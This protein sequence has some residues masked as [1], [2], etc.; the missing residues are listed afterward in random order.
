MPPGGKCCVIPIPKPFRVKDRDV[1]R[2]KVFIEGEC[3]ICGHVPSGHPLDKLNR[4]HVVPKGVGGDDVI[5]NIV[6][7]CGSGTTGCHG[8][9]TSR[10]EDPHHPEKMTVEEA[11]E[12]FLANLS[13]REREYA[14]T[15]KYPGWLEDYYRG[16]ED[17]R[18]EG[19]RL[20][21]DEGA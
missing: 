3:R 18:R 15:K 6:P 8:L 14:D 7:G 10:R 4:M 9:L 21:P 16:G 20:Y 17:A 11:T 5:D 12:L 13:V 2:D 1:G 19:S